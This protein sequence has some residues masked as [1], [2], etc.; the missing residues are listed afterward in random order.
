[1]T[2]QLTDQVRDGSAASFELLYRRYLPTARRFAGSL[3]RRQDVDDLVCDAFDRILN[4]LRRGRGPNDETFQSYLFTTI[5][6]VIADRARLRRREELRADFDVQAVDADPMLIVVNEKAARAE[7]LATIRA[8][9]Q[10]PIRWRVVVWLVDIEQVP[11]ADV[12]VLL[13]TTPNNVSQLAHRAHTR[14][15]ELIVA[16]VA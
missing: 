5:R 10:L 3:A 4:T 14:L 12:A 13:R 2:G 16:G 8:V 15:R 7:R 1:M 9:R 6:S 11:I